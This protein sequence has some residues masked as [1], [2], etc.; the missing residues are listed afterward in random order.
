[1]V[2]AKQH[3]TLTTLSA[4]ALA[5]TARVDDEVARTRF[6]AALA[7]RPG[8]RGA[9]PSLL[10]DWSRFT[11]N[12]HETMI[13]RIFSAHAEVY[14]E[15][16]S[17]D[18]SEPEAVARFYDETDTLIPL[19]LWWHG[20][21]LTPARCAVGAAEVLTRIGA[22]TVLDFGC[23]IGSTALV[24]A[25][26]GIEPIVADVSRQ[27]V[28]FS[29]ERLQT[30]DLPATRLD[31][32]GGTGLADL[33][34]ASVHGVVSF[35]VFE[36]IPNVAPSLAELDRV[37]VPGA[38]MVFNQVWVVEEHHPA[39]YTRRGDVLLWLADHGYRLAH[40]PNVCWIAQKAPLSR[41]SA[42]R[43]AASIRIR[44][45]AAG[46]VTD[47]SGRAARKLGGQVLARTVR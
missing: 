4:D 26:A 31:L 23:G 37:C 38:A 34:S 1:M 39:H 44:L 8:E 10:R 29:L 41:A 42:K 17:A 6:A 43:Q 27:M 28:D 7:D 40:V 47:R 33:P 2:D 21:E 46:A 11:G 12:D 15:W 32:P 30:R 14:S 3:P 20:T 9:L 18:P 35:D 22:E 19:L 24:L 45:A 36:H 16:L 5:T 25:T 13:E